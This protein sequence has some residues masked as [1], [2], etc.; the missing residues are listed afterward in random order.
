MLLFISPDRTS[1]R[2]SQP[3]HKYMPVIGDKPFG[4]KLT[5]LTAPAVIVEGPVSVLYMLDSDI[6]KEK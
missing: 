6:F 3:E 2:G 4:E 5:S 1:G